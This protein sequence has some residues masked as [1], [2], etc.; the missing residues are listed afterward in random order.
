M[1]IKE[2]VVELEEEDNDNKRVSKT[3]KILF[4]IMALLLLA[5][6]IKLTRIKETQLDEYCQNINVLNNISACST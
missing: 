5:V 6:I 2:P 3:V 1:K 4:V